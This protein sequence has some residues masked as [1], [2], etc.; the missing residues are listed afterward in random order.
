MTKDSPSYA[1]K[2]SNSRPTSA[3]DGLSLAVELLP[4]R[5]L[6]RLALWARVTGPWGERLRAREAGLEP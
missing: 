3:Y 5:Y 1:D 2:V 4:D 6:I